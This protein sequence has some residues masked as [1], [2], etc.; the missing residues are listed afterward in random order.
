MDRAIMCYLYILKNQETNRYYIGS[1]ENLTRRVRQHELGH[2]RTTAVLK[3]IKLV[4]SEKYDTIFEA[5][6]RERKLKSYKSKKYLD[7][8]I[9]SSPRSS[10]D[11][12]NR[13]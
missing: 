10:M 5:R 13:F 12:A 9:K 2:T 1:T 11:R 7:W 8:L 6:Q 4:Y 3:T